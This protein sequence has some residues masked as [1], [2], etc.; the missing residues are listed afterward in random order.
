MSVL[1]RAMKYKQLILCSRI[2]YFSLLRDLNCSYPTTKFSPSTYTSTVCSIMYYYNEYSINN[3]KSFSTLQFDSQKKRKYMEKK[4]SR[5]HGSLNSAY[6]SF[7]FRPHSIFS[8]LY[9]IT[10]TNNLLHQQSE[11]IKARRNTVFNGRKIHI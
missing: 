4:N 10:M 1:S 2:S 3:S 7:P 6:C 9:V 5:K 8:V 11:V